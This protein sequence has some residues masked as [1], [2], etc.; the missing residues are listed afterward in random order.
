MSNTQQEQLQALSER[1]NT[2]ELIPALIHPTFSEKPISPRKA[3]NIAIAGFLGLFV[4]VGAALVFVNGHLRFPC[5]GHEKSPRQIQSIPLGH[6]RRS[7]LVRRQFVVQEASVDV[8]CD[9][10]RL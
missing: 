7:S 2:V 3:L 9:S 8:E 1:L 4:G 6:C 10:C 5:F